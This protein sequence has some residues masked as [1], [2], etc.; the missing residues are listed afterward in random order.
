[1]ASTLHLSSNKWGGGGGGG[2]GGL[3]V[4]HLLPT[5]E[6]CVSILGHYAGYLVVDDGPYLYSLTGHAKDG[7]TSSGRT[8]R[9]I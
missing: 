3:V 4:S 8:C 6:I 1:M 5:P 9:F 7:K 2:L